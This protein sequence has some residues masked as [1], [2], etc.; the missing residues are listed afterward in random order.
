MLTGP[1]RA[2]PFSTS[3]MVPAPFIASPSTW[4]SAVTDP[5]RL[6]NEKTSPLTVPSRGR[7]VVELG[8]AV[9]PGPNEKV[10]VT[11]G[12]LWWRLSW[13]RL[14][15]YDALC[16]VRFPCHSPLTSA[17]TSV[18]WIQSDR[19]QPRAPDTR[20]PPSSRQ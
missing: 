4:R 19:V 9:G 7:F 8:L 11:L 18:D 12:P 6:R 13:I 20:S 14:G 15:P 2:C 1:V 17:V 5:L 16:L 10:P 3:R